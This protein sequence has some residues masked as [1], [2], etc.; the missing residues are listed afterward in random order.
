MGYVSHLEC[1]VCKARY[2]RD[3]V[4]NLCEQ[5][6]RP[7]HRIDHHVDL[8][9]IKQVAERRA[10]SRNHHRQPRAPDRLDVF[11]SPLLRCSGGLRRGGRAGDR[12]CRH[13]VKQQG[14]FGKRRSPI[15]LV[16]LGIY[17]AVGH[18]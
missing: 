11:E 8:A 18:E 15:M 4:M 16:D 9:V 12:R 6:G 13:V 2:P 1:T 7:I 17:M 3:R 14:P 10:P 5:D